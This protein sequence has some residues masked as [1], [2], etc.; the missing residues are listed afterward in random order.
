MLLSSALRNSML[1]K[2]SLDYS[3]QTIRARN[4]GED[5]SAERPV[6]LHFEVT[7]LV[8]LKIAVFNFQEGKIHDRHHVFI[9]PKPSD[10]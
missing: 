2:Y 1:W 3:V 8:L 6:P 4:V 5:F 7:G 9:Q 10:R